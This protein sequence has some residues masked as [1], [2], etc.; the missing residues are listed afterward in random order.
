MAHCD[1]IMSYIPDGCH[2][3]DGCHALDGCHTPDGCHNPHNYRCGRFPPEGESVT[4]VREED[5]LKFCFPDKEAIRPVRYSHC[6]AYAEIDHSAEICMI[7][8]FFC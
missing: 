8:C 5:V 4:A 7:A 2:T 1:Y 6:V 3:P